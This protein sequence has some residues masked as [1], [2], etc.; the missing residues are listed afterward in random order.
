MLA[1][2]SLAFLLSVVGTP[3]LIAVLRANGITQPIHEAVTQHA[4][5][6]G[7]PVMGGIALSIVAPVAYLAGAAAVAGGL[8]GPGLVLLIGTVAGGVV[9]GVDDIL[10]VKRARNTLGLRE[11][12]K[13]ILLL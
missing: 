10:K 6:A 9:G 12:Q 13:S 7:T 5:K 4:T 3:W 11:R 1:A 2:G 8:G